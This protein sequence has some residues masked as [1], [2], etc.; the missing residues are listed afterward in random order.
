MSEVV[1]TSVVLDC[2]QGPVG[3]SNVELELERINIRG[4]DENPKFRS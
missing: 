3:T 1:P 2:D 4:T